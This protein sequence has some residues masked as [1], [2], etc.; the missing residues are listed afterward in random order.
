MSHILI[1]QVQEAVTAIRKAGATKNYILVPGSTYSSAAALPTEAGPHL[2]TVT[3]PS[4]GTS[5]LLFDG[6]W[7][8][9]NLFSMI[10][11]C[12]QC[13]ATLTVITGQSIVSFVM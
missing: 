6:M 2:L 1:L 9:M 10:L 5:K 4:G 3:D 8:I 12:V 7:Y 13:T 11:I